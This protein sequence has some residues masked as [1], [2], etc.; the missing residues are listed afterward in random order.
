LTGSL[1]H[2]GVSIS[3][4]SAKLFILSYKKYFNLFLKVEIIPNLLE[5]SKEF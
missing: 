3:K 2:Y 1:D 4:E 5:M